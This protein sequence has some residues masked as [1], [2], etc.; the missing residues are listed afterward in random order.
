MKSRMF[1][2]VALMTSVMLLISACGGNQAAAPTAAPAGEAPAA[3]TAPAAEAP[4]TAPAAEVDVYK[5]QSMMWV[6][7]MASP[8]LP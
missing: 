1:S 6:R 2:W 5:R 3:T 8:I 4:T 7:A